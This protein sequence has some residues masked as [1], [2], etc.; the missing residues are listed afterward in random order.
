MDGASGWFMSASL[1]F[2]CLTP[3]IV[4]V[5]LFAHRFVQGIRY[6]LCHDKGRARRSHHD[7]AYPK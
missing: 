5:M 4:L 2:P 1:G 6:Y 7:A 3:S